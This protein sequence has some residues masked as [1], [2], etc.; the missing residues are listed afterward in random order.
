MAADLFESYAVMLVALLL[1][2]K[3]A[4]GNYGLVSR[5]SS[6]RDQVVAAWRFVAP[7]VA[8]QVHRGGAEA[9]RGQPAGQATNARATRTPLRP[10]RDRHALRNCRLGHQA[11]GLPGPDERRERQRSQ[12]GR[13][14]QA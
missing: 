13:S 7:A 5:W 12:D 1:L 2:G 6:R 14:T 10:R 11:T 3:V 4:F 9:S 8:A